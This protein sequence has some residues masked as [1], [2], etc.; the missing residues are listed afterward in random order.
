MS[1]QTPD[2]FATVPYNDHAGYKRTGT[3]ID[4]ARQ[5]NLWRE[6]VAERVLCC[7][8][9]L[10][11]MTAD[12][13]ALR[14]GLDKLTVRPRFSELRLPPLELVSD[15]GERRKI[16]INGRVHSYIVWRLKTRTE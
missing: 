6:S 5:A 9:R 11:P 15:S 13:C 10:G 16:A 12:E 1:N 8:Q 3:S 7:L 4:A 14:L 2:F